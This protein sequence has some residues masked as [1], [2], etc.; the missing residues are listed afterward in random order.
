MSR[1]L[2]SCV[3]L[4]TWPK[5]EAMLAESL[6][7]Y[8]LQTYPLRRLFV[9]NDGTP[10]KSLA[11]DVSVVNLRPG[12]TIGEKRNEGLRLAQDS[13]VAPWD[14]DDFAFPVHLEFL[15]GVAQRTLPDQVHC[16]LYAVANG[17]MRVGCVVR[18][19]MLAASI[20]WAPIARAMGGYP[21]INIAEDVALYQK[22]RLR[23]QRSV[24]QTRLTYVYRRHSKNVTC[25]SGWG[26]RSDRHVTDCLE[27]QQRWPSAEVDQLQRY[28]DHC[29]GQQTPKLVEP[30]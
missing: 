30:L 4:T 20:V 19:I 18:R 22:V 29:R 9:V 13:W 17:E 7:A 16:A 5:R 6:R 28:L 24:H 26:N 21:R 25:Q 14:D 15:M 27:D 12:L 3:C 11:K 8:S 1:D 10:L 2:V 23:R